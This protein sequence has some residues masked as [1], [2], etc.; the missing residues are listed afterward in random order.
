MQNAEKAVQQA[1]R[2]TKLSRHSLRE[3]T[4]HAGLRVVSRVVLG[5]FEQVVA[6][7]LARE[8]LVLDEHVGIARRRCALGTHNTERDSGKGYVR[9][10]Q[11]VCGGTMGMERG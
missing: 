9:G 2:S 3:A 7:V 6:R 5:G 10:Q 11:E 8:L 1:T 4:H